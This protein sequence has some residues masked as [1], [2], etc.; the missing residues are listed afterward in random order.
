MKKEED[1]NKLQFQPN[2]G[3][4]TRNMQGY[5]CCSL[6][7]FTLHLLLDVPINL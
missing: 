6:G 5:V 4:S 7:V 3:S 2:V 1:R